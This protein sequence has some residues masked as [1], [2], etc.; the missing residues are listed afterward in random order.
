MRG[1]SERSAQS[2][3]VREVVIGPV[4]TTD[5]SAR[6]SSFSAAMTDGDPI[7]E[8][9]PGLW[10]WG[11]R[12]PEWHPGEFG[13]EVG[14]YALTT[15][16]DLVLVDPL[17]PEHEAAGAAVL[18][19]LD[20][21]AAGRRTTIVV[22]IN[23]H[24]RSAELLADRFGAQLRGPKNCASKLSD[25][26]RLVVPDPGEPGPAGV[27]TVVIGSPPRGERPVWLPSH[28]A[29]AFG[30]ALVVTP[31]GE[32]RIWD[33]EEPT[34]HRVAFIRDRFS[35]TLQ[36]LIDRD[37]QVILTTHGPPVLTGGA[38]ALRQAI[39]R[40]PWDRHRAPAG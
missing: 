18:A 31:A 8:L 29:V 12:H 33:W 5:R 38:A 6:G 25:P 30:D 10:R 15:D 7:D 4:A 2:R 36:P 39:E 26:S 20:D 23:Y 32:L 40:G 3:A 14:S 19:R 13:A 11:A 24:V 9:A 21:L 28:R 22:T 16:D 37:P 35:P 34:D 17:V 1:P 27:E